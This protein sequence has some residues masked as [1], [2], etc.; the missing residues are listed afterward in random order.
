MDDKRTNSMNYPQ[1]NERQI[2]KQIVN[3]MFAAESELADATIQ[4]WRKVMVDS[5]RLQKMALGSQPGA[6][7]T[8]C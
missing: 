7:A 3:A 5:C 6:V 8:T 2:L 1:A 4:E